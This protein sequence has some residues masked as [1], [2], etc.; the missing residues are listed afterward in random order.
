M[1][2]VHAFIAGMLRASLACRSRRVQALLRPCHSLHDC[3]F[4]ADDDGDGGS[5]CCRIF[6]LY[7]G[8]LMVPMFF[9][10]SFLGVLV[11][12]GQGSKEGGRAVL[13]AV[14]LLLDVLFK[15][16]ATLFAECFTYGRAARRRSQ[17]RR[18]DLAAGAGTPSIDMASA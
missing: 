4:R 17:A 9:A 14:L 1:L 10:G 8:L 11:I 5:P 6:Q 3:I 2:F 7:L 16:G 12:F 13:T 15:I 18:A